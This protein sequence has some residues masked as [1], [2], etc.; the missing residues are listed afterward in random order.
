MN[1]LMMT[2]LPF[3]AIPWDATTPQERFALVIVIGFWLG[4]LT[5]I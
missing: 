2:A 5:T 1:V 4:L 3:V